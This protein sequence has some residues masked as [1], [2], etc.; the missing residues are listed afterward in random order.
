MRL[1]I[2]I[3]VVCV[4]T[5][6]GSVQPK[7]GFDPKGVVRQVHTRRDMNDMTMGA[8]HARLRP[9]H[10][11]RVPGRRRNHVPSHPTAERRERSAASGEQ[12]ADDGEFLIDTS[13]T[14]VPAADYQENPAVA[15]DGANFLVVWEDCRN[16][17]DYDIYGA[18][19]TPGGTVLDPAGFVISQATD[20]QYSPALGFDGANF[21]VAWDDYRSGGYLDVYG[22]RVTPAGTVLDPAGFVIS[23]AA[24]DQWSS[25]LGF[26]GANFLVVWDDY[27]SGSDFDIYGAR[28]TRQGTVLDPAGFVISQA[29]YD[30]YSPAVGFDRA[31]FLVVWEDYRSG[32]RSDV[33]GARVTPAGTVLE[34]QGFV[35]SQAA[36]D[37]GSPAVAFD[38]MNFLVVWEDFRSGSDCDVY[39]A[40]V[41]PGGAVLDPQ[42]FVISQAANDQYSPAL[43]FDGA[44]FLGVWDDYRNNPDAADIY[45][46]RVS[47]S[48]TVLDPSG[49][50]ISTA[51]NDQGSPALGFDG[52]NF[53]VVWDDYRNDPVY[54]DIY[55]ARVTPGGTVLDPSGF[56]ISQAA[57]DQGFPAL[58]FDG[59]NFLV[60]WEDYRSGSDFDIYG[61]RVTPAGTVLDPQGF[62]ISQAADDQ[63]SSALGFDGAN[64]LVVWD[65]YR[66]GGYADIYGARVTP[67]GTV[68]DPSGFVI[69]QADDQ[70]SPALG[71]DGANFLVV[72]E[73]YR[74][75]PWDIYG[76]RVTPQGTVLDPA[77]FVISRAADYQESPAL[78]FDGANFL[79]AWTDGRGSD[80]DIYGAR[81]TPAGA[82]L[83]TSGLVISRA[84]N[85]QGSPALGFDGANL[86]VVWEDYRSGSGRDIYGARVTPA[87]VVSDSGPVVRQEGDQSAPALARGNGSQLF[88]VYQGW[89]ETVGG[90]SYNTYRI[91][92]KP[93]PSPG[94]EETPSA[95]APTTKCLPTIVR[96]V[97]RVPVSSFTIHAS[98]FDVTGRQVMALRPGPNDVS[99]LSPGVYFVR[100]E[101][102]T[103]KV[104][105]QR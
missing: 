23:Q 103:R 27:R 99:R 15:F 70:E 7:P 43:G 63:W 41:T 44:N 9:G 56:V 54:P 36:D 45:G 28:V 52:A 11:D 48:G 34:P 49:I 74:S 26:D 42:G 24:D 14:L 59:A 31:N 95:E 57:G 25:A 8:A 1:C 51:A 69:S 97:L 5:A 29:D 84:A 65:D 73:D 66:S 79:V 61:A 104:V 50:A 88:L 68:L 46:A 47:E 71:F 83:D 33:Y 101:S 37:Q 67:A 105:V 90:K 76:A 87:G 53:L 78:G 100:D 98:L 35:I 18:R 10:S 55:G 16:G 93:N 19:V 21:L 4:L 94:I 6:F 75:G 82:V 92:G 85:D 81:V 2:L 13:I 91:W 96:G 86:L 77:G 102:R 80:C 72:W 89:A 17:N 40:R 20:D 38:S 62:V 30:Q 12:F 64:F 58:G 32:S 60:V 22:A 39:G 3:S